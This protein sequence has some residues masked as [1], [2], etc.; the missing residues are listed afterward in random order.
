MEIAAIVGRT[1]PLAEHWTLSGYADHESRALF[2]H[3]RGSCFALSF[4]TRPRA[5]ACAA[6]RNF[7]VASLRVVLRHTDGSFSVLL[8]N[9]ALMQHVHCEQDAQKW[10]VLHLDKLGRKIDVSTLDALVF[11]LFQPSPM[12]E[13]WELQHLKLFESRTKAPSSPLHT[14]RTKSSAVGTVEAPIK[15][16]ARSI[17]A[18]PPSVLA[19][20]DAR[21]VQEHSEKVL[22][23]L[24]RLRQLLHPMVSTP[25]GEEDNSGDRKCCHQP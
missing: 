19:I 17:S 14:E 8:E 18:L 4:A 6:F 13:K 3:A 5:I 7:Y 10:H 23:L 15:A 2:E 22:S 9:H 1:T 16:T 11:Y 24:C 20:A 12:F 25:N 21:E